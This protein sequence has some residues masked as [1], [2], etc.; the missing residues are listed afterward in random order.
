MK[1]RSVRTWTRRNG[2][3]RVVR[4]YESWR[5]MNGRVKG[6]R[7]RSPEIWL[8]LPVHWKT[9]EEFR[10][11]ALQAGYCKAL[12]SLDRIDP[13][14]GYHPDNCQWLSCGDNTRRANVGRVEKRLAESTGHDTFEACDY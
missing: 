12:N 8:G 13:N 4:L 14:K 11:W 6:S 3:Q 10:S 7:S 2:K 1:L 9:F 5:N